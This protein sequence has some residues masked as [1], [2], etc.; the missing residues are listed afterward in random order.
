MST[1]KTLTREQAE[2]QA[3]TLLEQLS[4]AK[5]PAAREAVRDKIDKIV[6][7]CSPATQD[8]LWAAVHTKE[9]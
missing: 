2:E 5:T 8:R 6:L 3:E 4:L 1:S 9:D 7:A